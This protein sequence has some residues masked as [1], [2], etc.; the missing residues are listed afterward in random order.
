M[1]FSPTLNNFY[2]G[3]KNEEVKDLYKKG[4]WTRIIRH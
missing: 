4:T 3:G 1:V 2:S